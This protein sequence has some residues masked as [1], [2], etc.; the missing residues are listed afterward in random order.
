METASSK[1][2]RSFR[3]WLPAT[4]L[5]EI[6]QEVGEMVDSFLGETVPQWRGGSFPRIDLVE[7]PDSL[8]LLADL[9]GWK[10]DE[11]SVDLTDNH[12]I[13]GGT[14]TVVESDCEASCSTGSPEAPLGSPEVI[15]SSSQPDSRR[16]HRVERRF[17]NFTRSIL[18]PCP[19]DESKVDATLTDGVLTVRLPKRGDARRRHV[20]VR[21]SGIKT[22]TEHSPSEK[23]SKI[24]PSENMPS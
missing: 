20:P 15:D 23:S 5:N 11:I 22:P 12:L 16:Y 17:S 8:E 14:R 2:D 19:V 10:V 7:L 9:P 4:S 6:R 18:L 21:G 13:L 1:R 3:N 24:S